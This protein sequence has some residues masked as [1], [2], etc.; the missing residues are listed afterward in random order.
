MRDADAANEC[1]PFTQHVLCSLDAE[2]RD[3]VVVDPTARKN[4]YKYQEKSK[5]F[6]LR[7]WASSFYRSRRHRDNRSLGAKARHQPDESESPLVAGTPLHRR[8]GEVATVARV[9]R[10]AIKPPRTII[11]LRA[12]E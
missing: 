3:R 10:A 4:R 1:A 12:C 7:R 9:N 6:K 5:M 11:Y 8:G 2:F